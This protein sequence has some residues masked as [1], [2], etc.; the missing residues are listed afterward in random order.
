MPGGDGSGPLGR[1]PLTGRGAGYCTGNDA[2]GATTAGR[3]RGGAGR[4]PGFGGGRMRRGGW[5]GPGGRWSRLADAT[6]PPVAPANASGGDVAQR[7]ERLQAE[8]EE[9]RRLLSGAVAAPIKDDDN[10]AR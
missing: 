9:L 6:R 2:P 4:G 10:A 7:F 5:N 3:G 8:V 1:G